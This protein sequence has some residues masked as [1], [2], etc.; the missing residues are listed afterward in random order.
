[1]ERHQ[2]KQSAK[3]NETRNVYSL[4]KRKIDNY[5][6]SSFQQ[7]IRKAISLSIDDQTTKNCHLEGIKEILRQRNLAVV[8]VPG[9]DNCFFLCHIPND[10]RDNE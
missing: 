6:D 3:S 10:V 2:K 5:L 1:M 8:D 9:D 7:N 4:R